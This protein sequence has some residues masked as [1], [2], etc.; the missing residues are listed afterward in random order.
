MIRI[1]I[2][3]LPSFYFELFIYHLNIFWN[4]VICNEL[5]QMMTIRNK[6]FTENKV[7]LR[8][9]LMK[10]KELF[11][12]FSFLIPCERQFERQTVRIQITSIVMESLIYN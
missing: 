9:K 11:S 12:L 3:I 4:V 1:V 2:D 8:E 6:R 10:V 5:F 7:T